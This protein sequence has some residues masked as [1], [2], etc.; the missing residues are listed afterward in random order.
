MLLLIELTRLDQRRDHPGLVRRL[1]D[2]LDAGRVV[3]PHDLRGDDARVRSECFFDH[4]PHRV[5][6]ERNVVVAEEEERCALDDVEHLVGRGTEAGIGLEAAD[7]GRR[8]DPGDPGRR[9]DLTRGV[10]HENRQRRIVLIPEGRHGLI[11]RR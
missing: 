1:T 6:R 10:D 8:Q 3:P 2:A 11:E 4:R 5:R 9:V 7:V